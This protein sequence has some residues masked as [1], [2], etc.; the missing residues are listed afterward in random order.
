MATSL[1][2]T[3]GININGITPM[4]SAI[5]S[6]QSAVDSACNTALNYNGYRATI[7]AAMAGTQTLNNLNAYLN[8]LKSAQGKLTK[9][10]NQFE[11]RLDTIQKQYQGQDA[12]FTF[13]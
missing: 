1:D 4:K 9:Q 2:T 10:L 5:H 6:Y 3:R 8:S 7:Q 11:T 12:K 13:K